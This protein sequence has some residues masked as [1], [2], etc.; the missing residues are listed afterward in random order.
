MAA[1]SS[2]T[3]LINIAVTVLLVALAVGVIAAL[4]ARSRGSAWKSRRVQGFV[5]GACIAAVIA[6]LL[7]IF[8]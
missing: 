2:N 1:G 7:L 6:G 4:F 5:I 8:V 3:R